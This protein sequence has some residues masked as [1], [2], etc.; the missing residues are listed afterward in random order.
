MGDVLSVPA[1][2]TPEPQMGASGPSDSLERFYQKAQGDY[3]DVMARLRSPERVR[4]FLGLF[5]KD[6]SYQS[7]LDAMEAQDTELAFRA[8]HTLK[9]TAGDMGLTRL[10]QASSEVCEA[11]RAQQ[12]G[13]AQALLPAAQ[14]AYGLFELAY[15][16]YLA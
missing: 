10:A 15:E 14:A 4:R 16:Q 3:G 12:M 8:S 11:L 9:G 5:V 6:P 1:E 2:K 13:E 7:L